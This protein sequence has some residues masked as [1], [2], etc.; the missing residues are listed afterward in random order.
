MNGPLVGGGGLL[1]GEINL[2]RTEIL[3]AEALGGSGQA[4]LEQVE[5]VRTPPAVQQ[6]LDRARVDA[7]RAAREGQ[8]GPGI[9]L[10]VRIRAPNQIF[11]RGRGLDVELGGDLR[12][13]GTTTDLQPVGGFELRRG[14][15]VILGQRIEFDEGQLQLVGN[16]DPLI[17]FVAETTSGDVTAIVTVTGRV[18]S[19]QIT[20]SSEPP[21][22]Q[23]EVLARILFNRATQDL[24]PF[25]IAQLA[26]AAA[27]LAGGGGG[28]GILS[29]LRSATG[30]DDLDVITDES[31]QAAVRAGRYLD[32]NIY[33]TVQTDVDGGAR[34]EITLE[35]SDRVSARGSVGSDGNS[36]IGIFYERDY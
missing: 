19:P 16:L 21:L 25:Q 12:L 20:F 11:V 27:E 5:H 22:P 1:A 6:T 15:L 4:A 32:E 36:T 7:S 26:A 28:P 30:L 14:R 17:N 9:G 33:V 23:D 13:R 10:D 8:A 31:G 35:L 34:A 29:Q 18:S 2:E 24:S 3:V